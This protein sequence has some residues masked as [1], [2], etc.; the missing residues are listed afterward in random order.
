MDLDPTIG[1]DATAD[2]AVDVEV[3]FCEGGSLAVVGGADVAARGSAYMARSTSAVKVATKDWHIDPGAHFAPTPDEPDYVDTWPAHC[4]AGTLGSEFHEAF[5]PGPVEAVFYKG[6]HSA[7]Y[8]GFEGATEEGQGASLEDY[9]RDRGIR[10]VKIWGIAL[11]H[12]VAATALDAVKAGFETVVLLD[13][14][15]GVSPATTE[16]AMAAMT[17]AGV[18]FMDSSTNTILDPR[19]TGAPAEAHL[20]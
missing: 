1:D 6:L 15:V 3:D 14:S 12:C 19:P 2:I 17:A 16:S 4:V 20:G 8:S 11:S 7:A 9:L 13:L 5:D 10:R 18:I